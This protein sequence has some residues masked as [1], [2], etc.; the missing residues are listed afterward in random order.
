MNPQNFWNDI[1]TLNPHSCPNI[2]FF[3]FLGNSGIEVENKIILEIGFGANN[4]ADLCELKK[5]GANV[6]G[7]DI[8][9]FYIEEFNKMHPDIYVYKINAANDSLSSF[10]NFDIIY[11]RDLIYYLSDSEIEFH[12][13]SV[14]KNLKIGGCFIFQ[15]IENDLFV[16]QPIL[17]RKSLKFDFNFIK[18]DCSAK[19]H[20]GDV[21]PLRKLNIDY[22]VNLAREIG[23]KLKGTKTLIESYSSDETIYRINRYIHLEK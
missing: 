8:N 14:F 18:D 20:K 7:A 9:Q 13:L 4:G 6:Y 17:T 21:N 22:L 11:H 23:F 12:L 15:F 10:I 3:R 2:S 16:D 1:N 5:R 19:M